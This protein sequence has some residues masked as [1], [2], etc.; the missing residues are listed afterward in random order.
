MDLSLPFDPTTLT[1]PFGGPSTSFTPILTQLP[2]AQSAFTKK[3]SDPSFQSALQS[4]NPSL[5]QSLINFDLTRVNKGQQPLSAQ[6]TLN[7]LQSAQ[8]NQPATPSPPSNIFEAF[9][10][11]IQTLISA[12]FRLPVDL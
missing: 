12:V 6:Q 7:A 11:A 2:G 8:T 1:D 5:R 10:G 4:L 9:G 3:Y